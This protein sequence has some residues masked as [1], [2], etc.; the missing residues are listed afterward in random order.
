M[1]LYLVE[2]YDYEVL[3]GSQ[4]STGVVGE[5]RGKEKLYL[6]IL[7]LSDAESRERKPREDDNGNKQH[8]RLALPFHEEWWIAVEGEAAW[9]KI[10]R[11]K[12]TSHCQDTG[13]KPK[14][15]PLGDDD[16]ERLKK[17]GAK[18]PSV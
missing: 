4:Q 6:H 1:S 8:D 10:Y 11:P 5:H 14:P 7:S 15:A 9:P 3:H 17:A 2:S 18:L 12:L 16:L 13:V